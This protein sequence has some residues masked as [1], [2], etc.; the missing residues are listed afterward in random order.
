MDKR[1]RDTD[2]RT[3]DRSQG[4]R[5]KSF[6]RLLVRFAEKTSMQGVP[7][8]N[9]AKLIGARIIWIILLLAAMAAMGLHLWYLTTQYISFPYTAKVSFGFGNLRLPEITICNTN[10]VHKGRLDKFDGADELKRLIDDISP[11]NIAPEQFDDDEY[12][13]MYSEFY[14]LIDGEY[15]FN[16]SALEGLTEV[17]RLI[18]YQ[19]FNPLF[20]LYHCD[21]YTYTCFP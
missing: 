4:R 5:Y 19:L 7:Y 10:P 21:K 15:V 13:E 12:Y 8:I 2:G 14:T 18:D 16:E 11:E 6:R 3:D 1:S 9:N 20:Q 17:G